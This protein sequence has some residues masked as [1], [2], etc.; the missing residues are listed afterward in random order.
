MQLFSTVFGMGY[1]RR[2]QRHQFDGERE[3]DGSEIRRRE[4]GIQ[5]RSGRD[6]RRGRLYSET[7]RGGSDQPPWEKRR[8]EN[9]HHVRF[10]LNKYI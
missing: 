3:T 6:R 9:Y 1:R 7:Q 5:H 8:W 4:E 10:F 2:E